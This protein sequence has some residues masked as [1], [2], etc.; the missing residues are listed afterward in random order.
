MCHYTETLIHSSIYFLF[1]PTYPH[2]D[3]RKIACLCLHWQRQVKAWSNQQ[4]ITGL[5][6]WQT[7][8]TF[9]WT[10]YKM[11]PTRMSSETHGDTGRTCKLNP[12]RSQVYVPALECDGL[13]AW[14]GISG[15]FYSNRGN[16]VHQAT[17]IIIIMWQ[18]AADDTLCCAPVTVSITQALR[19]LSDILLLLLMY[20]AQPQ[21]YF[22][23]NQIQT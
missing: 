23:Q 13:V 9:I 20:L 21:Y 14:T 15:C 10:N 7:A 3:T 8:S 5:T 16:G 19:Q 4:S 18:M 2:Q 12:Q 6:H 11:H 1:Q 22:Q 17:M